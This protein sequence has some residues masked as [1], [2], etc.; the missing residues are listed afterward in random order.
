MIRRKGVSDISKESRV[1][2]RVT[3]TRELLVD[4]VIHLLQNTGTDSRTL[5]ISEI[6]AA[7]RLSRPTFYQHYSG[8]E[9]L[10]AEAVQRRLQ[11][12]VEQGMTEE[13]P[14]EDVPSTLLDLLR[15]LNRH[16]WMYGRIIR[17]DGQFGQGRQAVVDHT[18]A[19]FSQLSH[20]PETRLFLAGGLLA[21][22]TP[23][24]Q[25]REQAPETEVVAVADRLWTL[26]RRTTATPE[27]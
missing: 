3:R 16:R 10:I 9:E 6:T 11:M 19:Y 18:A 1:D 22:L 20:E 26:I 14:G 13:S 25:S 4:A 12:R 2:P 7:A 24:M 23:W 5:S 21:V 27:Q 15:E 17:G 8:P